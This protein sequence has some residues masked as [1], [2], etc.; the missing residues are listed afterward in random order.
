MGQEKHFLGK[1][2]GR[3]DGQVEREEDVMNRLREEERNGKQ[4]CC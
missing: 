4:H 3:S 1:E 2:G